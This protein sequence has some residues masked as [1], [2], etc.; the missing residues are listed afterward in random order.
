MSEKIE[1]EFGKNLNGQF[2]VYGVIEKRGYLYLIN[3]KIPLTEDRYGHIVYKRVHPL[4][5]P[6]K[7]YNAQTE[8]IS[9]LIFDLKQAGFE[10]RQ[11]A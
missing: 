1:I 4:G 2:E 8:D 10:F 3:S 6:L 5:K 9:D 11:R 7:V